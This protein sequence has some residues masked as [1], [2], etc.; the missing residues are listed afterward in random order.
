MKEFVLLGTTLQY[1]TQRMNYFSIS[2]LFENIAAQAEQQF[3]TGYKKFGNLKN[4]RD[5]FSSLLYDVLKQ[6]DEEALAHVKRQ[7]IYSV[8]RSDISVAGKD[9]L[10]KI[11]STYQE[12][13]MAPY[14][15]L[16]HKKEAEAARRE[17]RKKIKSNDLLDSIGYTAINAVGNMGTSISAG[18]DASSIYHNEETMR[19]FLD[20][21]AEYV[22]AIKTVTIHL[23]E[24][25][26]DVGYDWPD[27]EELK[28]AETLTQN[29]LNGSVPSEKCDQL[30][31]QALQIDP[32]AFTLYDFLLTKH[33]DADYQLEEMAEC[34]GY[35]D[36]IA[37]KASMLHDKFSKPLSLTYT[38]ENDI[39]HLKKQVAD[40][41]TYLGVEP[42]REMAVL[43]KQWAAIDLRL[44]TANGKEYETRQQAQD[45][46]DDIHRRTE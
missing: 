37:H 34:F 5:Q 16:E 36:F 33:G 45:V 27:R 4:V 21:L 19:L 42:K 30:A 8:S 18:M 12:R 22:L 39:L 29:I 24:K 9:A 26:S 15:A 11:R 25:N 1:S 3:Q 14:E 40:Y 41:A 35:S 32:H 7:E 44:R 17:F 31:L 10:I 20:E 46:R 43:D 38:D 6:V 13:I 23:I 28:K 2:D